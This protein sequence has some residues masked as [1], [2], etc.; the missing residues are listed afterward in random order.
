MRLPSKKLMKCGTCSAENQLGVKR[1]G[2]CGAAL[3]SKCARCDFE[4]TPGARF[5]INCG[6]LDGRGCRR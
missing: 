5:C 3:T 2:S 1:C 4:N 6:S